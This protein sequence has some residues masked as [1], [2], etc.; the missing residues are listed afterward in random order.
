MTVLLRL[1][2]NHGIHKITECRRK[3]RLVVQYLSPSCFVQK[4]RPANMV[5]MVISKQEEATQGSSLEACV[6]WESGLQPFPTLSK[7]SFPMG[8][9]ITSPFTADPLQ[10]PN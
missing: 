6:S 7:E 1:V 8:T 9:F 4:R 3:Q 5:W 10:I 2:G